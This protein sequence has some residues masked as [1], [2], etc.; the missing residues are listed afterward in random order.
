MVESGVAAYWDWDKS[1]DW[2]VERLVDAIFR[3]M[4]A[5]A[6]DK[7][8]LVSESADLVFHLALL[9]KSRELSLLDVV[10]ELELRHI[11]KS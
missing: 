8:R 6:Q 2:S 11:A 9:L 4:A 3:A 10:K 7:E 1:D 5:A